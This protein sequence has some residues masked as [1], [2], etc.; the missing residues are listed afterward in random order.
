MLIYS[1]SSTQALMKLNRE[2]SF[3]TESESTTGNCQGLNVG[4]DCSRRKLISKRSVSSR[5][6]A[7]RSRRQASDPNQPE[8]EDAYDVVITFPATR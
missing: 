4:V 1:N 3:C 8:P 5:L 2:W 6:R 7:L